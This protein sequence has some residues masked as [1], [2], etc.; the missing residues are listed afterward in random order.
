VAES[1]DSIV[2]RLRA[3]GLRCTPQRY[4]VLNYLASGPFHSTADEIYTAL[5]ERE[6][7]VSRATVYNTLRELTRARLVREFPSE[8]TAARYD[9]NLHPHHHF[10]CDRCGGVEDLEWFDL[11]RHAGHHELGGHRIRSYEV[12][13]RGTC[14]RCTGS[15]AGSR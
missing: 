7:L 8:S 2:E 4:G 13:F 6:P 9:A 12:I 3:S 1:P 11:P 10:V 5:T 14:R 15:S